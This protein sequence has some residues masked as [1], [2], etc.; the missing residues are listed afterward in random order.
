MKTIIAFII[1]ITLT[2]LPATNAYSGNPGDDPAAKGSAIFRFG[3][4][5]GIPF[6][7][8]SGFGPAAIYNYDQNAWQAGP[9]TISLGGQIGSSFFHRDFAFEGHQYISKWSNVSVVF[10]SA[11][12]Y[13]W[14][15]PGLDTYAGLG[16]GAMVTMYNND[17]YD[18]GKKATHYVFLPVAFAGVSYFF[19]HVVGVNAEC[20]YNFTYVSAG[21]TFRLT[22]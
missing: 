3:F 2:A 11:W 9:G 14:N 6:Y 7:G 15:V 16:A 1:L 8:S 17:G 10:R 4:G 22:K 5:A 12:H 20:G 19:N 18:S 13:G 21:L